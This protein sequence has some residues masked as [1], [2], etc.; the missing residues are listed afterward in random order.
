MGNPPPERWGGG[1]GPNEKSVMRGRD[2]ININSFP[3]GKF[4][5]TN[6]PGLCLL[7]LRWGEIAQEIESPEFRF[8]EV[9]ISE[10]Q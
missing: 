7:T 4:I 9:G 3:T 5:Y 10:S 1:G 8:P 2:C 6:S